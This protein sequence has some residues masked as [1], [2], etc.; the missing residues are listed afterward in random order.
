MHLR[1]NEQRGIVHK[2]NSNLADSLNPNEATKSHCHD[3]TIPLQETVGLVDRIYI[4]PIGVFA[5]YIPP[6]N[7]PPF[8]VYLRASILYVCTPNNINDFPAKQSTNRWDSLIRGRRC[9]VDQKMPLLKGG[10]K[11]IRFTQSSST[12]SYSYL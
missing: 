11:R 8:T 9:A 12:H 1:C 2:A 4:Y 7:T 5:L 10:Y 3:V 6:S